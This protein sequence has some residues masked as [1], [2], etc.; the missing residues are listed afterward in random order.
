[1]YPEG[2]RYTAFTDVDVFNFRDYVI[3]EAIAGRNNT[4]TTQAGVDGTVRFKVSEPLTA[5]LMRPP[6][7]RRHAL[8]C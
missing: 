4:E 7:S 6:R 8:P 1:M 5:I 2:A 3:D